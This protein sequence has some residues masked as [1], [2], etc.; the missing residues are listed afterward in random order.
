MEE[1]NGNELFDNIVSKGPYKE[2][3]AC[4]IMKQLLNSI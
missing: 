2:K 3:D 1:M 4:I